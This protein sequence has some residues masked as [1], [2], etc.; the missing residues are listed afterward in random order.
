MSIRK[1]TLWNLFGTASPMLMGLIVLPYIYRQIGAERLGILTIVWALIG[2]FSIFDFGL[3][4]ALTQKIASHQ[5]L[6]EKDDLKR[7]VSAGVN[8]T[9]LI[10]ILGGLVAA[11]ILQFVGIEWINTSP[12][13]TE[14]IRNS[15]FWVCVAIPI[16]TTTTGLR[17]VLEGLKLFEIVNIYKFILGFLNF[18]G[19]IISIFIFGSKLDYIVC[20][21][22]LAR[23]L[24]FLLYLTKTKQHAS[25]S[26]LEFNANQARGLLNFGSWMTLTNLISPLMVVADR[27]II[28]NALGAAV[29]AYYTI[30]SDFLIRLLV[31]PAALTTTLFPVFSHTLT[32]DTAQAYMIYRKSLS[33]IA[34]VMTPIMLTI[35]IGA[36][37]GLDLWLGKSFSEQ[38]HLVTSILAIGILFNSLAQIPHSFIQAGGDARTTALI[39]LA[40]LFAYVPMLL[41]TL[42][43]FGIVGAAI[44]WAFRAGADL[45]LLNYF[46][47]KHVKNHND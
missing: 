20:F 33:I 3:G 13:Y 17:G 5:N 38:A 21:L 36:R 39:H 10:G 35:M 22:V 18:A 41:I 34:I 40:E 15:F 16:T 47:I 12:A 26:F 8:L 14:E 46:A 25:F 9:L 37:F 44:S 45:V 29:V 28:S 24:I 30:P 11:F 32:K 1:N 31:L 42:H 2:Y 43:M 7:I 4:R 23:L 6:C 27:F 19:P